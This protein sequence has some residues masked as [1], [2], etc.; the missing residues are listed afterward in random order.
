[1]VNL[2][3]Q[4]LWPKLTAVRV[5]YSDT[6]ASGYGGYIVE[7]SNLVASQSLT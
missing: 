3:G 2:Y 6:T 1:M 7:H 5:A 4:S